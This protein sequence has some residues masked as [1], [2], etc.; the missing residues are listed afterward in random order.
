MAHVEVPPPVG[1]SG[2]HVD[3]LIINAATSELRQVYA[4]G[5]AVS[6]AIFA[7]VTSS[8]GLLITVNNPTTAVTF[9]NAATTAVNTLSSGPILVLSSGPMTI[10]GTVTV[11]SASSGLVQISG[12]PLV[13]IVGTSSGVA[14]VTTSGGLSVNVTNPTT[15][16]TITNTIRSLSSGTVTLSSNPTVI[17]ASSGFASVA[18]Q[19]ISTAGFAPVT[20]SA[21]LL[22]AVSSG[23]FTLSSNPTVV[24][25]SIPSLTSGTVTLSSAPLV[26]VASSGGTI[27]V[28]LSTVVSLSSVPTVT[29]TAATN[30]WSSAPGF[31]MPIVSASSGLVQLSSQITVATTGTLIIVN[32]SSGR[33]QAFASTTDA[34]APTFVSATTI[35]KLSS[36]PA[37][38]QW[39]YTVITC[40]TVGSNYLRIYDA[41]TSSV[42]MNTSVKLIL[43]LAVTSLSSVTGG[44]FDPVNFLPPGMSF[45]SGI[46]FDCVSISTSTA[47]VVTANVFVTAMRV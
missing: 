38:L 25:S 21:G 1:S 7:P 34:V 40:S 37:V 13:N 44:G 18:L 26:I 45:T 47:A 46:S 29:A 16:V 8:G 32:A 19:V 39:L 3:A 28:T 35:S 10:S 22:V 17:T 23:T 15:A 11:L 14:V 5:S 36:N 20:S 4:I 43:P 42:V 30:P 24:L 2:Q 9:T 6:S 41:T 12:T 27:P 31:N 33:V